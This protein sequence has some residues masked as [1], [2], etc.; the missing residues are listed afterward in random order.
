[1]RIFCL[2]IAA[3]YVF[4]YEYVNTF[5]CLLV[6]FVVCYVLYMS[7]LFAD[8]ECLCRLLRILCVLIFLCLRNVVKPL[9]VGVCFC[10]WTYDVQIRPSLLF[11][12]F[13]LATYY[14]WPCRLTSML[15]TFVVLSEWLLAYVS[16]LSS[17]C[18]LSELATHHPCRDCHIYVYIIIYFPVIVVWL[19]YRIML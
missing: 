17:S 11:S 18:Q 14:S 15:S 7:C 10:S 8:S 2:P 3:I 16:V 9:I 12:C 4:D 6:D 5:Q 13:L 19:F 1:M